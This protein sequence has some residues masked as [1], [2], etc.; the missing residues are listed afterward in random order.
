M[1]INLDG[2][3]I[4]GQILNVGLICAITGSAV[5]VFIYCWRKKILNFGEGPSKE[6]VDYQEF[7]SSEEE[8]KKAEKKLKK[9]KKKDG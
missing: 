9:G 2:I 8:V 5:L 4:T 7:S 6:M 1:T 3:G